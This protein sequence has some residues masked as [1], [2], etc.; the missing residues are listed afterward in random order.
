MAAMMLHP[1]NC[2]EH[3]W[4]LNR[5]EDIQNPPAEVVVRTIRR[6]ES[7]TDDCRI[8]TRGGAELQHLLRPVDVA[9]QRRLGLPQQRNGSRHMWSCDRGTRH[10]AGISIS[11]HCGANSFSRSGEVW[12]DAIAVVGL[13]RTATAEGGNIVFGGGCSNRHRRGVDRRRSVNRRAFRTA[14]ARAHRGEDSSG[15]YGFHNR[16]QRV[17]RAAFAGWTE[18]G[19][20]NRMRRLCRIAL[21]RITVHRI[22][23]EKELEASR[24]ARRRP[25]TI[26]VHIA[27]RN[28]LG[29]GSNANL[30]TLAVVTHHYA[31]GESPV[32]VGIDRCR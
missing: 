26:R 16:L 7:A 28:V 19:V 2:L 22:G 20:V 32:A 13:H 18:P 6:C 8:L 15:A 10:A 29:T 4:R 11:G 14:V 27:A 12:F 21:V 3:S 24:I 31:G 9:F 5:I 30:I 17:N 23:R 1:S 25:R